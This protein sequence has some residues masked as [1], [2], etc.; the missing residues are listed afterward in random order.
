MKKNYKITDDVFRK[1]KSGEIKC[2]VSYYQSIRYGSRFSW[3]KALAINIPYFMGIRHGYAAYKRPYLLQYYAIYVHSVDDPKKLFWNDEV[4]EEFRDEKHLNPGDRV[5]VYGVH[6]NDDG[7]S[8][9]STGVTE[10][11][12]LKDGWAKIASVMGA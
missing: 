11:V 9:W 8:H 7:V 10:Y 3:W 12:I 6:V 2:F 1:L 4:M 5:T